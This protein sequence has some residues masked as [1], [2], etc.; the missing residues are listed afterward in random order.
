MSRHNFS[1]G[2]M[3]GKYCFCLTSE[4]S[5]NGLIATYCY[6]IKDE[7]E[8]VQLAVQL[9]QTAAVFGP[10]TYCAVGTNSVILIQENIF[11]VVCMSKQVGLQHAPEL[12]KCYV[13]HS[14]PML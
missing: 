5:W 7:K 12:Q 1:C 14:V 8:C 3:P 2:K 10:S 9:P 13:L 4:L 6:I 11:F